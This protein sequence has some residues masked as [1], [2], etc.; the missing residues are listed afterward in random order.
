M[1]CIGCSSSIRSF[2]QLFLCRGSLGMGLVV[3][4]GLLVDHLVRQLLGVLVVLGEVYLDLLSLPLAPSFLGKDVKASD[5]KASD[6][7]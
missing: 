7:V 3:V 5:V 1:G 6:V 4:Q 2:R